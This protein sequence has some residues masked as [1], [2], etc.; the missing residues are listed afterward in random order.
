[1]QWFRHIVLVEIGEAIG[2]VKPQER[3]RHMYSRNYVEEAYKENSKDRPIEF[4]L[5]PQA[6]VIDGVFRI[7]QEDRNVREHGDEDATG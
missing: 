6:D 1:M 4:K 5:K 3:K 2:L 7:I